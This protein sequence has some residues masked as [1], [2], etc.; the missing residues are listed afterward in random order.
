MRYVGILD[1]DDILAGFL[2]TDSTSED[3]RSTPWETC[4]R[5]Y[6]IKFCSRFTWWNRQNHFIQDCLGTWKTTKTGAQ[7]AHLLMKPTRK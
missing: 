5:L 3:A 6:K 7:E 2:L 1:T 4:L